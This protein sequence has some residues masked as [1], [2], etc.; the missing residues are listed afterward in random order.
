[1]H[2][3]WCFFSLRDAAGV[4]FNMLCAPEFCVLC[5]EKTLSV[6]LGETVLLT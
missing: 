6:I 1:M 5:S 2:P 4:T 3:L